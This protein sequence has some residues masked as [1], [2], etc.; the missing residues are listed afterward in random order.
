MGSEMCI[1]DR[2]GSPPGD[3]QPLMEEIR[4]RTGL[5]IGLEGVYRWV[6]FLPSRVDARVPVPNRY[7]G[8]FTDGSIKVRGLEAR[9]HDSPPW[10]TGVQM[11]VLEILARA[12]SVADLP[13]YVARAQAYILSLIHIS[14][15]TRPY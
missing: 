6:A 2:D 13:V 10:V 3:L 1:R 5:S 4:A 11:H 15:P 9:R 12:L 8:V 7:F 14:E